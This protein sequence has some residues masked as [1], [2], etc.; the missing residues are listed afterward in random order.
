M[1]EPTQARRPVNIDKD[2]LAILCCPDTK[3]DVRLA[4]DLLIE[5]LNEAVSRGQLKNRANKPVTETLDGGLIRGDRK[6]L[7]PIREDIPVMLIEEGIPLE[8]I[9]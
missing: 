1:A 3:Q 7:Y 8:G 9:I 5:K 2:L 6:I 4:E